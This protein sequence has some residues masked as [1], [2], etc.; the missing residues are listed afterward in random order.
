MVVFQT[1]PYRPRGA[2]LKIVAV[3]PQNCS[4]QPCHSPFY[5]RQPSWPG[6]FFTPTGY[7]QHRVGCG[8]VPS[9][10]PSSLCVPKRAMLIS[11]RDRVRDPGRCRFSRSALLAAA[12]RPCV[13][14]CVRMCVCRRS[15]SFA[16]SDGCCCLLSLHFSCH[17]SPR[18]LIVGL[19][20]PPLARV[21]LCFFPLSLVCF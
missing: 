9:F 10:V 7:F 5:P 2:G 20:L 17:F 19:F 11:P 14:V 3:R 16:L 15:T 6:L 13:G 18:Q 12:L 4:H 8:H 1:C 21:A